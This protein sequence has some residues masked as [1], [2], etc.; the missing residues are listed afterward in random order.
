MVSFRIVV[1]CCDVFFLFGHIH[2]IPFVMGVAPFFFVCLARV[3]G[4]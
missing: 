4:P 1:S 3:K 2:K